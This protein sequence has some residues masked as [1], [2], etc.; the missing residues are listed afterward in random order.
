MERHC[1]S[2]S[3]PG[4]LGCGEGLLSRQPWARL[5]EE[6]H[7]LQ[8]ETSPR[9]PMKGSLH[10]RR[11][12]R[13]RDSSVR[14]ELFRRCAQEVGLEWGSL[15]EMRS[16]SGARRRELCSLGFCQPNKHLHVLKAGIL[17][18]LGDTHNSRLPASRFSHQQPLSAHLPW[19][20][21]SIQVMVLW[22]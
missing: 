21:L 19:F 7:Q 8:A 11:D 16:L 15:G 13:W 5:P 3:H 10:G 17:I 4:P 1:I 2:L 6:S 14:A 20:Q 22:T 12:C 18:C 9:E